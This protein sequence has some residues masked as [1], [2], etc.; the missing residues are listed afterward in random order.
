M[1]PHVFARP[2]PPP[3]NNQ[4]PRFEQNPRFDQ[5]GPGHG[6]AQ[7]NQ[8]ARF[9]QNPRFDQNG[10]GHGFAQNNQ[11]PHFAHN[12]QPHQDPNDPFGLLAQRM[13]QFFD[14]LNARNANNNAPAVL[15]LPEIYASMPRPWNV[16]P[17][18]GSAERTQ[19]HKS[20]SQLQTLLKFKGS[21]A[22]YANW[23]NAF[24]LHVHTMDIPIINK[25]TQ[26]HKA[27]NSPDNPVL[28]NITSSTPINEN[29]YQ[30]IINNL[31]TRYGQQ[32]DLVAIQIDGLQHIG[33][34]KGNDTNALYAFLNKVG[35]YYDSLCQAQR[36]Q[37]YTSPKDYCNPVS[38]IT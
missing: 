17:I 33:P 37:E 24:I 25:L 3:R 12:A 29:G 21:H 19:Y 2:N 20:I 13:T 26:M 22:E 14:N 8:G 1:N 10:P 34:L 16:Y 4:G 28:Q 5:N 15:D 38:P 11:R 35:V 32:V 31:E 30:R 27:L 9:D 23:R 7:N 18:P 36:Q 6:F